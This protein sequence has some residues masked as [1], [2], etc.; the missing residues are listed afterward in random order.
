MP[1]CKV[2]SNGSFQNEGFVFYLKLDKNAL[3]LK[4]MVKKNCKKKHV[5]WLYMAFKKINFVK[6]NKGFRLK[7]TLDIRDSK[8]N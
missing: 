5:N 1:H 6:K 7:I 3:I 4:N 8:F 2:F